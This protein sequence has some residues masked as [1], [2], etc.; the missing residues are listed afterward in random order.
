[1]RPLSFLVLCTSP[2]SYQAWLAPADG[3]A[4]FARHL[5]KGAYADLG[6]SG[7]SRMS[8]SLNFKQKYA[9]AF[10]RVETVHT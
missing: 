5:R 1:V 8:G 10:P 9:P 4:G 2:G 7:A 6:T 3:D